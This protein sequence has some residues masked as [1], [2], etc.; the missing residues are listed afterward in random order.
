MAILENLEQELM[1]D[2]E[3]VKFDNF[4][5]ELQEARG[6]YYLGENTL[7]GYRDDRTLYWLKTDKNNL[8]PDTGYRDNLTLFW[9]KGIRYYWETDKGELNVLEAGKAWIDKKSNTTILDFPTSDEVEI[10]N[11][12]KDFLQ[13]SGWI[14]HYKAS[15][16]YVQLSE[17]SQN[18]P[19]KTE[20]VPVDFIVSDIELPEHLEGY[21]LND[22]TF[23]IKNK[24]TGKFYYFKFNNFS[25]NDFENDRF[26][27]IKAAREYISSKYSTAPSDEEIMSYLKCFKK[28]SYGDAWIDEKKNVLVFGPIYDQRIEIRDNYFWDRISTFLGKYSEWNQTQSWIDSES[29]LNKNP[30]NYKVNNFYQLEKYMG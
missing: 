21:I 30:F 15:D 24:E 14:S 29:G 12:K 27:W 13:S 20:K 7:I 4:G 2:N 1:E 6:R 5:Q 16:Y 22:F 28:E 26:G 3:M 10:H 19:E 23:L 25:K 9:F 17:C 11:L 18:S 8:E